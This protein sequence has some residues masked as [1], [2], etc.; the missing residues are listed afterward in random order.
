MCQHNLQ[1][2]DNR[3]ASLGIYSQVEWEVDSEKDFIIRYKG[4]D[5]DDKKKERYIKYAV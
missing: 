4:G 2:T 3:D 5:P 1:S